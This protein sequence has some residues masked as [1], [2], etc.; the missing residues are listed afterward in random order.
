MRGHVR[1]RGQKWVVIVDVGYD[2][3]GKR[4][5]R[6]HSG[7][8]TKRDASK[9]LTEIANRLQRG[10]YVEPSKVTLAVFLREW[11][12]G[13]KATIRPSTWKSYELNVERHII[14]ALGSL[15]L[16]SVTA[17]RLNAFYGE[18]LERGHL[19]RTSGGGLSAR[20]VRY[21]HMILRRALSDACRWNR[22]ARN[23]ADQADPPRPGASASMSTLAADELRTFLDHVSGDRLHAVWMVL[24]TTG[25]RR[26]EALGLRWRDVDL[27]AGRLAIRQTLL[28]VRKEVFFST[29]KT[30]KSRRSV[31]L[32]PRTVAA[33]R[34]HRAQ[35]IEERLV[36]SGGW[37]DHDLVFT[38]EDG[39][40]VHPDRLSWAFN[41]H[42]KEADL[43]R[44]RLHDLRHTH[45]SLALAAG[46]HPK[47]VSE[48]LG[49]ATVS[50]T[51]D[52][53]SHAIPAM[54]EEAAEKVAAVVFG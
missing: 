34:A 43:P 3:N 52:T 9:A 37:P 18:L 40:P 45:A 26:G 49:H 42:V 8:E 54:Q 35:Q 19:G 11:L 41:R 53:Y 46:I 51:L 25:V 32:D 39:E 10:D 29:P 31:A 44:I 21:I 23:P 36:L 33:L 50:I 13:V 47:V 17:A 30:A 27:E 1:R 2:E 15:P 4:K 28:S 7:F 5:Q 20:T 24:A 14:P 16:Q 12:A 38:R 22:L 6:W 48:R